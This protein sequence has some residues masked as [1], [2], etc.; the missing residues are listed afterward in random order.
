MTS[1]S[2][3]E[4]E[5]REL[6]AFFE[7]WLRGDLEPGEFERLE[8]ALADDF[9]MVV[10]SGRMRRREELTAGLREARGS[11]PSLTIR[12]EEPT[13]RGS[14]PTWRLATYVERQRSGDDETRRIS[15]VLFREH[16][17]APNGLRWVHVHETW[18]GSARRE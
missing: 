3:W 14:G 6:H 12:V 9:T 17:E 7:G 5:I 2:A 16:P 4:R 10:P 18:S 8:S 13:L 15:T 1:R 11:D